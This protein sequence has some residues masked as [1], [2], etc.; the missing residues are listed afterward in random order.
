M[1]EYP[2]LGNAILLGLLAILCLVL[3]WK[4][5]EWPEW[6]KL[7]LALAGIF[8][9]IMALWA[10]LNT[11]SFESN[12]RLEERQRALAITERVALLDK[13]R[14]MRP[15][16]IQAMDKYVSTI[17]IIAGDAGPIYTLRLPSGPAAPLEFIQ[18]LIEAGDDQFLG[19]IRNYSE[20]SAEREWAERFTGFAIFNGWA[21]P[22]AGPYPARW[23]DK[24]KCLHAL[25]LEEE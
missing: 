11:I 7:F 8:L 4:Q 10:A 20:G 24:N 13:I 17:E 6:L 2:K 22:A 9:L 12:R 25:G 21:A 5:G 15:D 14:Q 23:I 3:A 19:A 16:Q 1:I 18:E